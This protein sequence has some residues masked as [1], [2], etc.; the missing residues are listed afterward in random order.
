[1]AEKLWFS[2]KVLAKLSVVVL[3]NIMSYVWFL[4][5]RPL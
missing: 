4:L 3:V 2:A 1:M 5:P